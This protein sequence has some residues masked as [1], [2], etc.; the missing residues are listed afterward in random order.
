MLVAEASP[1]AEF[2][3]TSS[4]YFYWANLYKK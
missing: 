3:L 1:T 4:S 2:S